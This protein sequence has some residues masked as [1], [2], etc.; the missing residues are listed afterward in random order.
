MQLLFY[1]MH[2]R[3]E[4]S[5]KLDFFKLNLTLTVNFNDNWIMNYYFMVARTDRSHYLI[6]TPQQLLHYR[7]R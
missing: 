7:Q 5:P 2:A 4:R 1:Y 3:V 6:F